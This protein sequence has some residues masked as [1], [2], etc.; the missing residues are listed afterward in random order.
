MC[1]PPFFFFSGSQCEYISTEHGLAA[2]RMDLTINGN[3]WYMPDDARP[4]CFNGNNRPSNIWDFFSPP[5]QS[6]L[7]L[8]LPPWHT[9]SSISLPNSLSLSLSFI[10]LLQMGPTQSHGRCYIIFSISSFLLLFSACKDKQKWSGSNLKSVPLKYV[11]CHT[12]CE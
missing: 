1:V 9:A 10:S 3:D 6:L 4:V 8:S 11:A 7:C 2:S 12:V 5:T